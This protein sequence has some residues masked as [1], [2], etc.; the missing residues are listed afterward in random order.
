MTDGPQWR[1]HTCG[2]TLYIPVPASLTTSQLGLY[3]DARF[4]GRAILAFNQHAEQLE[5]LSS[6]DRAAF[7]A[8]GVKVGAAIKRVTG[9]RRINY[10]VLGNA[11]PHLH[12]QLI[13]RKP[14]V[15]PL[16]TRPP[17]SDSRP[18]E[19]LDSKTVRDLVQTL[20]KLLS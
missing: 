1:C 16:P 19:E 15:E 18:L 3:S 6:D 5:E 7:W 12:L 13:P 4:P 9:S 17:W 2:F 14:E 20:Q 8:D 11:E 10:A